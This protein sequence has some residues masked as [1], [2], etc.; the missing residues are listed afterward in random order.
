MAPRQS[1]MF[2]L[3][4]RV[5][6]VTG[7]A[8]GL[9]AAMA[10]ALGEAGAH[11]ILNDIDGDGLEKRCAAL[12]GRGLLAEAMAFDVTDPERVAASI[13]AAADRH[14]RLDILVN[15]AGIAV[16]GSA[17]AHGL[18]DWNRVM[19]VD[20]TAL[21]L[22]ARE[23]GAVMSRG[24]YG[25]II[26]IASVLGLFS[27]P[28]IASYVVAKHGVV[29]LTRALASELGDRGITCNALAPGYF[30]TSMS[31]ALTADAGFHQM[32]VDRTP[33]RRWARP[34]ELRGPVVFLASSASS[35]VNGHVLVVDGGM[36]AS[37]FQ[38]VP[39]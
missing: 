17:E 21:F 11:V 15:N 19:D 9:G 16:Y 24:G 12:A 2:S 36:T 20:L 4:G 5:A 35:F 28:G 33:A 10:E 31:D 37:L 13:R 29:G 22:M 18:A 32:I 23:A 34:E 1:E 3:E 14:D 26:N 30:E 38:Q 25:R 6:L 39:A 27:R 7:A 8:R